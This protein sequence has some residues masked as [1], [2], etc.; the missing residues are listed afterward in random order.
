[1]SEQSE[2]ISEVGTVTPTSYELEGEEE[3]EL[4]GRTVTKILVVVIE[5]LL[6]FA[7]VLFTS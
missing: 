1:M 2:D 4:K 5:I 3:S 6:P 7:T